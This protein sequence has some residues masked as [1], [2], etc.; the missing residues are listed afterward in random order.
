MKKI[1]VKYSQRPE[2]ARKRGKTKRRIHAVMGEQ[3]QRS[4]ANPK[5]E[6]VKQGSS[7]SC[8]KKQSEFEFCKVCNLNHNQGLR[9][10]YFPNHKKSLSTFLSRFQKKI[11]DIRFF[12]KNPITLGPELASR[13]RF[14]C[15][16]CDTDI[17]EL[18]SSFAWYGCLNLFL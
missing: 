17:D 10:K 12:L 14:W 8:K 4:K 5:I 7:N 13:N 2:A 18:G 15:V 11:S 1:A 6:S 9:H 3:L 16:F